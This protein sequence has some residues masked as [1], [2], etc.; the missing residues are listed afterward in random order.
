MDDSPS[1]QFA[2]DVVVQ[3]RNAG[4]EAL[5]A[6]GC[7]R[8]LLLHRLPKDYDVATNATPE[9]VRQ[10]FGFRRTIP[11][12]EAF[13]VISVIGPK[14]AGHVEVATFRRDSPYS[15]GRHP[16]E[17]TFCSAE[18]DAQRRDFTMN[19]LFLDPINHEVLDYVDGQS[20]LSNQVVRAIGD[21]FARF[22][23]DRLRLLRAVCL[24]RLTTSHWIK[25][26]PKR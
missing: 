25:Q 17:V 7:V 23:E 12:G 18:E 20:D 21:P 16:D 24:R 6:G 1:R 15:D 2:I 26:P 22:E 5:F 13:G 10:C 19:G 8:D 3:L 4:Y 9:Q 14:P 11:V